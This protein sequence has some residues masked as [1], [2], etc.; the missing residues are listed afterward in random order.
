MSSNYAHIRIV[1]ACSSVHFIDDRCSVFQNMVINKL[2]KKLSCY[3]HFNYETNMQ[4][5][6]KPCMGYTDE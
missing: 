1:V 3:L 5:K 6:K 4:F 2:I